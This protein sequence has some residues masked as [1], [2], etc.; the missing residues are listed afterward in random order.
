MRHTRFSHEGVEVSKENGLT[1]EQEETRIH[2]L[3]ILARLIARRHLTL[4]R[5][6][7]DE[8]FGEMAEDP[9]MEFSEDGKSFDHGK[10]VTP[11]EEAD[12]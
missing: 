7:S 11:S 4:L 5:A 6:E 10:S 8:A 3:R 2:G 12:G 9:G 1:P